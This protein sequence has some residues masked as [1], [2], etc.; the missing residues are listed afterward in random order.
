M[1][2]QLTAFAVPLSMLVVPL[3]LKKAG[4][5]LA[6][7]IPLFAILYGFLQEFWLLRTNAFAGR[8]AVLWTVCR[9]AL[10]LAV[11]LVLTL[12]LF[13]FIK[14]PFAAALVCAASL[15][16]MVVLRAVF[17]LLAK[18]WTTVM[19]LDGAF[20]LGMAGIVMAL[21]F[22]AMEGAAPH[23]RFVGTPGEFCPSW[24]DGDIP[25]ELCEKE[26]ITACI[27]LSCL[28]L[29]LYQLGWAHRLCR[30]IRLANGEEPRCAKEYL[31]LVLVPFYVLYWMY[32]RGT[33]ISKPGDC[34]FD[35]REVTAEAVC[36]NA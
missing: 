3:L 7:L 12:S 33:K 4:A 5:R 28:T 6:L 16:I 14:K 1:A 29:G 35:F 32:S 36:G 22:P 17:A 11:L 21:Q 25:A 20:Y 27:L 24:E 2:L 26:D 15:L 30:K 18:E 31:C 8:E 19:L 9:C 13:G 34:S 23:S 10:P